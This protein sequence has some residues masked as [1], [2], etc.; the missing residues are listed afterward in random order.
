MATPA[1]AAVRRSDMSPSDVLIVEDEPDIAELMRFHAEREGCRAQVVH[2]GRVAL[3]AIRRQPPD[4][5]V[6]DLM[7]PD[8]DGLE[9]CRRLKWD[10]ETRA[11]PILI[12]SARGEE[13]DVVTG[14]ELGAEDYVTKPFSPRVL[15]ARLRTILRRRPGGEPGPGERRRLSLVGGRLVIDDDRH[16]VTADGQPVELTPT[17]FGILRCLAARPG[18]VRTR[19]QIIASIHGERVVLTSR[20][21]DVHLTA[22]RRKLGELGG[23]VQTV[24]GVGY[25]LQELAEAEAE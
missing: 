23:C 9:L 17:E 24:R 16:L 18:F 20:T 11:I 7:L 2:S 22:I 10:Q 15:M 1:A 3:D 12:V 21:V 8:L 25:R 5:V 6:L 13:A 4:V 14:L 19:D